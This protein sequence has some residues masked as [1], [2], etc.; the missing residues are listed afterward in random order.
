MEP[1][2]KALI[3][4]IN[5][6]MRNIDAGMTAIMAFVA[7]IPG[8]KDVDIDAVKARLNVPSNLKAGTRQPPPNIVIAE[9]LD[10]LKRM[11]DKKPDA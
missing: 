8:A 11:A 6:A 3:D 5:H 1:N 10:R 2:T 4:E 9:I 7:S